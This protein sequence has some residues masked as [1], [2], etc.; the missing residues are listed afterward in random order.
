MIRATSSSRSQVPF[1]EGG[2]IL[3]QRMASWIPF[4]TCEHEICSHLGLGSSFRRVMGRGRYHDLHRAVLV[5][6]LQGVTKV[7]ESQMSRE[8]KAL[9]LEHF[10]EEYSS[11]LFPFSSW[12]SVSQQ[13]N[14]EFFTWEIPPMLRQTIDN[15]NLFYGSSSPRCLLHSLTES[16]GKV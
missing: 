12:S 1:S 16:S 2:C 7:R 6:S 10:A 11:Y 13:G 15:D 8:L 3:H 4:R 9:P 5:L 14:V